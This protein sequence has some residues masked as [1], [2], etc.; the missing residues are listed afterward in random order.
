[1]EGEGSGRRPLAGQARLLL[2]KPELLLRLLGSW[3]SCLLADG[4]VARSVGLGRGGVCCERTI[5]YY[6]ME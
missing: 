5:R 1:M 3:E 2:C 6:K 4:A